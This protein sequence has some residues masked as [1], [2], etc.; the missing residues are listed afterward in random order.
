M[1]PFSEFMSQSLY[2]ENGYYA[3]SNKVG[4]KGDFY[5]SVSVS[6][7]FGGAI[8]QYI[9]DLLEDS[10]LNL[11]LMIVEI[12]ADKGY[13]LADIAQFLDA[14]SINVLPLCQFCTIEPLS[15][16]QGIQR[17]RFD[18]L[19]LSQ[20]TTFDIY[21]DIDALLDD[22]S[23]K[24]KSLI[25]VSNELFDSFKCEIITPTQMLYIQREKNQWY[26]IW[27]PIPQ[28]VGKMAQNYGIS[29]GVLPFWED[30]IAHIATISRNYKIAYFLSFDYGDH[31][32]AFGDA[33]DVRFYAAHQV[34]N[35]DN[36]LKQKR[37]FQMLYQQ[38]DITYDVNF[39]LLDRLFESY[40]FTRVFH[41]TQV[42]ILI[43]KM[44][45]FN[46]LESFK[47]SMTDEQYTREINKVKTLITMGDRFKGFC[48]KINT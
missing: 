44:R 37:D 18:A 7:F 14:L 41:D 1:L 21:S 11:P 23:I 20:N 25:F 10:H 29:S 33:R 15:T 45:L 32:N 27:N 38:A 17:S 22:S 36:F 16:L 5:T 26:G 40:H 28:D 9:L 12:G 35:L 3:D 47:E 4:K 24:Q 46:L 43:Q 13:L 39:S 8:A 34:E 2:G 19:K 48:Y 31:N 42:Q 6:K 30:F